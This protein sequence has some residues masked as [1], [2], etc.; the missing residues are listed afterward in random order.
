[1]QMA[2]ATGAAVWVTSGSGEK[3]QRARQLGATGGANY[4]ENG[5]EKNLLQQSGG[6]DVII[7]GA[8]G[9]G[10]ALFP[11]LCRPGARIAIYGGTQGPVTQ[12]VPQPVFYKQISIYG[13]TM[14]SPQEFASM[15]DF[16]D[17]HRLV[18]VVDSVFPLTEAPAA[19][20]RMEKGMQFGKIVLKIT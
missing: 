19:F 8:G 6:F 1:M 14:G 2:I 7:D 18:P 4:T 10:F 3:I 9:P 13:S 20:E 12:L 5:W 16:V 11:R 15:L 17:K